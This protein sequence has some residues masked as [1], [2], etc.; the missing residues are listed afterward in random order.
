MRESKVRRV[1]GRADPE[2]DVLA[3]PAVAERTVRGAGIRLVAYV[4]SAALSVVAAAVLLRYLGVAD[5]G[6]YATVFALV[7]IVGGVTEA[8]TANVGIRELSVLPRREH[9]GLLAE[10]Q[11]VRLALTLAGVVLALAFTVLAGYPSVM[12][13][14]AA[15]AGAGL[16][17]TVFAVTLWVPLQ[18]ELRLARVAGLEL[19]RQV[20]TVLALVAAVAAGAGLAVLLGA[21]IPVALLLVVAGLVAAGAPVRALWPAVHPRRW[22]RLLGETVPY[23][24][25]T[26]I[27]LVYSSSVLLVM[28]LA[29]SEAETG[30]YGAASRIFVVLAGT[31]GLLVGS[32]F[33]VLA[34]AGHDDHDRLRVGVQRL[35]DA[36]ATL[37]AGLAIVTVAGAPVAIDVVAGPDYDGA[38]EP[39]RLLGVALLA[40][41][42]IALGAFALLSLRRQRVLIAVNSAGLVVC[43]A[44][45]L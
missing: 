13:E 24:T 41:Y 4:L 20:L 33:P 43:V 26:A 11:G 15:L 32:A 1:Y 28:S 18:A 35:F 22:R 44:L 23:A 12:V 45:A 37:G 40:S 25:A 7:T 9:E 39:L 19:L 17:L 27:G 16:L 29:A 14:G 34:R 6:R 21:Q 38:V 42:A 2:T 30:L 31:A 10:L 5:Y 8:G 36:F 3:A